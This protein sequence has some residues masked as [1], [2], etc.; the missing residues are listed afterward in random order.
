MLFMGI[1][2]GL[3]LFSVIN[4]NSDFCMTCDTFANMNEAKAKAQ[5]CQFGTI[6]TGPNE[7]RCMFEDEYYKITMDPIISPEAYTP[8]LKSITEYLP[9]QESLTIRDQQTCMNIDGIVWCNQP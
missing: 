8:G 6:E 4:A 9:T 2:A 5:G 7:N 1:A 3:L